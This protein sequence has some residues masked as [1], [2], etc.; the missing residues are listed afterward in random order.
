MKFR[1]LGFKAIRRAFAAA[2]RRALARHIDRY[3]EHE[4]QIG[5]EIADGDP[6]QSLDQPLVDIAERALIDTRGVGETVAHHP[7][8]GGKRRLDGAADMVFAGGSE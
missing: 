4:G 6:L 1:A 5:S 3:V 8:A 7:F 2:C